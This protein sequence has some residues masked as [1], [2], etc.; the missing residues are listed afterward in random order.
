VAVALDVNKQVVY[1][2]NRRGSVIARQLLAISE[3]DELVVFSVY[4]RAAPKALRRLFARYDRELGAAL[5]L[6][7]MAGREG[8]DEYTIAVVISSSWLDDGAWLS[9][10]EQPAGEGPSRPRL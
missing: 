7:I 6:P 4:P 9:A 10:F 5:G 1:A 8:G 3:A 2:R